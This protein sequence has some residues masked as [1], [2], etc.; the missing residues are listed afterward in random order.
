MLLPSS[1][2]SI[3]LPPS[4]VSWAILPRGYEVG[5]RTIY[6]FIVQSCSKHRWPVALFLRKINKHQSLQ[7]WIFGGTNARSPIPDFCFEAILE[8]VAH[9]SILGYASNNH[10]LPDNQ[11]AELE[12]SCFSRLP[13][14]TT[15]IFDRIAWSHFMPS[16]PLTTRSFSSVCDI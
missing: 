7:H 13:T 4:T 11:T 5:E 10:F 16:I 9:E 8:R 3:L 1:A 15:Y 12:V 14:W 6:S 2:L